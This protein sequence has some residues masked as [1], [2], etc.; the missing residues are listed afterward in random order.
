[1]CFIFECCRIQRS[2]FEREVASK[3]ARA[4]IS[5]AQWLPKHA[6]AGISS[7]MCEKAAPV[8]CRR[9]LTKSEKLVRA[10]IGRSFLWDCE[11]LDARC[12]GKEA[13]AIIAEEHAH[14]RCG[15][16]AP[17]RRVFRLVDTSVHRSCCFGCRVC[18]R[19][20]LDNGAFESEM[21]LGRASGAHG[22]V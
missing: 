21:V 9:V 13:G 20:M 8:P 16:L 15:A 2:D 4:V 22:S 19:P 1:M 7:A 3:H 5:I 14:E 18:R 17:A 12:F 10:V 6:R 11:V